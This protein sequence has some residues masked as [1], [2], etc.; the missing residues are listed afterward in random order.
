MPWKAGDKVWWFGTRAVV[1]KTHTSDM[2]DVQTRT[3]RKYR[4]QIGNL[5]RRFDSELEQAVWE[6][7][8]E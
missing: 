4:V 7:T 1:V 3:G 5:E 6:A 2:V 8:R